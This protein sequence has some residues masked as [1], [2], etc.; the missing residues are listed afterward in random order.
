[1]QMLFTVPG[2]VLV[3]TSD[4]ITWKDGERRVMRWTASGHAPQPFTF[5]VLPSLRGRGGGHCTQVIRR[6]AEM[7]ASGPEVAV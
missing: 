1:M 5:C 3:I 6:V 7:Q 2:I 4:D